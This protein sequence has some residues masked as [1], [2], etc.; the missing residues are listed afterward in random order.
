[1]NQYQDEAK[2]KW[3]HTQAYEESEDKTSGYSQEK[4][5]E[6][7]SVLDSIMAEFVRCKNNG[8]VPGS[9]EAQVLVQRWQAFLTENY[10]DCTKEILSAL[11]KMYAADQRFKENIDRYGAGTAAF[12]SEAIRVYCK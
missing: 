7:N 10:Y 12:I 11:G 3:G 6:V 8:G 1:M 2:E 5:N 9:C 4:W